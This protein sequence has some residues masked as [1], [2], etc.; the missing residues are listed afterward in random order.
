MQNFARK[1]TIPIDELG[2]DYQIMNY[3]TPEEVPNE[4]EDGIYCH[5]MFLEGARWNADTHA[6][7]ESYDKVLYDALPIIWFLPKKTVDINSK[8]K[9]SCPVYKTSARRG[10]LSTTGHSTNYVIAIKLPSDKEEKHWILR[11]V[12]TLYVSFLFIRPILIFIGF[13]WTNKT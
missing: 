11:G 1:Y 5:G 13:N 8:N 2:V 12:A 9:Y 7:A 10:V 3:K 4:P 6:L